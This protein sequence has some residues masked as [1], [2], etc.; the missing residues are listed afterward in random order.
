MMKAHFL[1]IFA[2]FAITSAVI[3][4]EAEDLKIA[5]LLNLSLEELAEIST[6]YSC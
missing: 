1:Y 2:L 6:I 3:A 5:K 4:D